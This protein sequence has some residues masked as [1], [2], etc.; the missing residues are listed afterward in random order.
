MFVCLLHV[1]I[2][3]LSLSGAL[4]FVHTLWTKKTES[5]GKV[6]S[7]STLGTWGRRSKSWTSCA[8]DS[9]LCCVI[10]PQILRVPPVKH[11]TSRLLIS[12]TPV[13]PELVV[14]RDHSGGGCRDRCSQ[15]GSGCREPLLPRYVHRSGL[16]TCVFSASVSVSFFGFMP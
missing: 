12:L 1:H 15:G 8:G 14:R 9:F 2:S 10:C 5:R 16:S 3:V 13:Q 11:L 4:D 7:L 6:L